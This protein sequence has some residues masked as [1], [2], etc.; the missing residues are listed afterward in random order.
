[1]SDEPLTA[2]GIAMR[3]K[4]DPAEIRARS[5][6]VRMGAAMVDEYFKPE[7]IE[8][9]RDVRRAIVLAAEQAAYEAIKL[10]REHHA[11]DMRLLKQW[12]DARQFEMMIA[13]LVVDNTK[14]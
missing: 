5:I 4:Y 1:M 7:G 3:E 13:P 11:H 6:A 10:E 14:P 9:L 8:D 12:L 2:K